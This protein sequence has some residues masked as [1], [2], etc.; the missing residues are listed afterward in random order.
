MP[1]LS[2]ALPSC[3]FKSGKVILQQTISPE[4]MGK[5][6]ATGKTDLLDKFVSMRTRRPFKAFLSWDAAAGK[7]NF[8]FEPSKYPARKTAGANTARAG[9]SA[10]TQAL[11][12]A[13]RAV[14]KAAKKP[15]AKKAKTRAPAAGKLPSAALAAVIGISPV[16]RPQAI[17]KVWAYVKEKGLQDA[18]DKRNIH[19]DP[20][21][22]EV[23][24][25]PLINMFELAGLLGKH[26]S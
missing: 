19:A 14:A 10:G 15:V 6:L 3:D 22:T 20:A 25:K 9:A 23:F 21:L 2:Q 13:S 5:L 7:V 4:Q 1:T 18:A 8:E 16:S 11:A 17:Q 12:A 26:L 24:G